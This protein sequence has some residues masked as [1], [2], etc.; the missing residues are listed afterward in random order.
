[1]VG[2]FDVSA[3][4]TKCPNGEDYSPCKCRRYPS[5]E[6]SDLTC[7][8][9]TLAQVSR[10]FRRTTPADLEDI[11]IFLSPCGSTAIIPA[12]LFNSHRLKNIRIFCPY[13]SCKIG[14][15]FLIVDPQAF[16]SSK[17][18]TQSI[19]FYGW[20]MSRFDFQFLSGFKQITSIT[21]Y[22]MSKVDKANWASFPILESLIS[23]SIT[24]ST[25]LN[26]WTT[27]PP[28]AQGLGVLHLSS[29]EIND[30]AMDRILNW[31]IKY[32]S[33]TL[34]TLLLVSNNLTHLPSQLSHFPKLWLLTTH[35]QMSGIELN[36]TGIVGVHKNTITSAPNNTAEMFSK[37]SN[38]FFFLSLL[39]IMPL[40]YYPHL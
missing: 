2:T 13:L 30:E 24:K 33:D 11:D 20:D 3:S 34:I 10:L 12:D 23:F 36:Q 29:N 21:F 6:L 14:K 18:T 1:M 16:R 26:E 28:L 32:S 25:G 4:Q 19:H 8:N 40:L 22:F 38:H 5:R 9:I 37:N 35:R 7:E 31:A 17:N 15:H 39:T 27:F